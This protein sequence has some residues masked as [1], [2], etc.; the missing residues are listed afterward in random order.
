MDRAKLA[1]SHCLESL[2][3]AKLTTGW[4]FKFVELANALYFVAYLMGTSHHDPTNSLLA[5]IFAF[6]FLN[7]GKEHIWKTFRH[8]K[9]YKNICSAG[10]QT[11]THTLKQDW[12]YE[13]IRALHITLTGGGL[14]CLSGAACWGFPPRQQAYKSG[15]WRWW[16]TVPC[17]SFSCHSL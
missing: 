12:E 4:L 8:I 6:I 7:C 11:Y 2:S 1:G 13:A 17:A 5:S 10:T 16:D 9:R 14:H 15:K 3:W